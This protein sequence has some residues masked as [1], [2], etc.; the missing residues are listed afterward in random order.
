MQRVVTS[1]KDCKWASFEGN[2]QSGCRFDLLQK[3]KKAGIQVIEAYDN[4]KEF[5]VI[6]R[7]CIF[8]RHKSSEA[9]MADVQRESY[10]KYQVIVMLRNEYMNELSVCLD[11]IAR[12]Q[13]KPQHITVV[14]PKSIDVQPF[15][16]TKLLSRCGIPWRYQ[17]CTDDNFTDGDLIDICL[18]KIVFPYYIVM[19]SHNTL[20]EGFSDEFND[21]VNEDFKIFSLIETTSCNIYA[22]VYHKQLSGNA[23]K[24]LKEKLLEDDKL[25]ETVYLL[26]DDLWT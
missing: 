16:V 15:K 1:C 22:T 11:S 24:P 3:Y 2:T 4:D 23:F 5:N 21:L 14:K 17:E 10:V 8:S 9:T 7:I 18:D 6:D 26:G 12:Q 13:I 20:A 25:S 19:T